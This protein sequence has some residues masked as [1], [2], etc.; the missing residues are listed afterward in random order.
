MTHIYWNFHTCK[1]S[2][3]AETTNPTGNQR[4]NDTHILFFFGLAKKLPSRINESTGFCTYSI[5]S[6]FSL[7]RVTGPYQQINEYIMNT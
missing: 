5:I 6:I 2:Y 4:K 7:N 1:K 3:Q